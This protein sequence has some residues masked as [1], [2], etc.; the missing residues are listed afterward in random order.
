M[1]SCKLSTKSTKMMFYTQEMIVPIKFFLDR[2]AFQFHVFV[3]YKNERKNSHT[4]VFLMLKWPF[5]LFK[6]YILQ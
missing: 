6:N 5:L 1:L 3:F 4:R 2:Y